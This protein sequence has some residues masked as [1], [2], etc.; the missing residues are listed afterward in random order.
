MRRFLER[1]EDVQEALG[2]V[3]DGHVAAAL[4]GRIGGGREARFAHGV[5]QGYVAAVRA[6]AAR[7][8]G[9]AWEKLLGQEV[10]WD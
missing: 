5:V 8:A 4:M 6:P 9:R 1:L 3:N 10:F 7:R 2:A